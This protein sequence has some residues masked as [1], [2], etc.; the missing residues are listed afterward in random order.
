MRAPNLLVICPPAARYL[1]HLDSLPGDP[2]VLAGDTL[3]AFA[4]GA[5]EESEVVLVSGPLGPRLRE[6]WPR[7]HNLK[8]IHSLAAGLESLLFPELVESAVPLTNSRGVFARSLSEFALAGMLHFAKDLSR[9]SRAKAESRWD[10][11]IVEELHDRVLGIVGYGEIGRATAAR[12][13]AFGMT[14]HALRR[15]AT[16]DSSADRVLGPEELP[17]LLAASDYLLLAAPLTPETKGMI[18]DAAFRLMKPSSVLLN[19]GRGPV[20]VESALVRALTEH[21]I[22]GAVLDVFDTEPLPPNHPL[23]VLP[24]VL[25]SP[26]CADNTDTWMDEAMQMFTGNFERFVTGEPLRNV[27]DKRS[28]Y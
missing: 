13:K 3:D 12:A 8:W 19:L 21:T 17:A 18:G 5:V 10:P 14:I 4:G 28:G 22:R 16:A 24:N 2:Y 6:L 27:T 23:W 25:I 20:V 7:L 26:H 1:R 15:H 9:M 11:F